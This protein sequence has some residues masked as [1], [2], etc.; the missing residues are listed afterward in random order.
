M[1]QDELPHEADRFL[2]LREFA[3]EIIVKHGTRRLRCTCTCTFVPCVY[4][5][6]LG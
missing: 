6:L 5:T 2:E 3:E 4:Y 1:L